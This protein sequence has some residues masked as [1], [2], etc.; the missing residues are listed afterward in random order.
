MRKV[1]KGP[2]AQVILEPAGEG[3]KEGRNEGR[4]GTSNEN[5]NRKNDRSDEQTNT[6]PGRM[7][8]DDADYDHEPKLFT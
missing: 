6:R 4:N 2:P 3:R 7:A 5:T 1:R 8:A